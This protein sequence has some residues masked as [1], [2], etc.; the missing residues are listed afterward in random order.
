[1]FENNDKVKIGDKVQVSQD[2]FEGKLGKIHNGRIGVVV[3][4]IYGDVI[5][6]SQDMR[7]PKL[8]KTYYPPSVIKKVV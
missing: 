4:I 8:E 5:F 7:L 6:S 1:M 3:D 2:A